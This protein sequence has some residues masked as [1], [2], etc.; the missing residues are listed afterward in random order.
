MREYLRDGLIDEGPRVVRCKRMSA[1]FDVTP[2]VLILG[3][4]LNMRHPV[5][6]SGMTVALYDV[7][8]WWDA[9]ANNVNGLSEA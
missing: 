5:T 4:A 8:F 2:G 9:L 1:N 3:D 7:Y 6:A